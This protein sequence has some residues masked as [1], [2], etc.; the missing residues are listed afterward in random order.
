MQVAERG[1]AMTAKV[2]LC[3]NPNRSMAIDRVIVIA[4]SD[5]KQRVRV[6]NVDAL[7][8]NPKLMLPF[9]SGYA[10]AATFWTYAG[11][12]VVVAGVAL[13]FLWHWWAFMP[14]FLLA[15]L[16]LKTT[17]QNTAEVAQMLVQN[18][19]ARAHFAQLGLIWETSSKGIMPE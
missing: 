3:P 17:K 18:D 19:V 12:L 8:K 7:S 9:A 2:M 11:L 4:E 16:V 15:M 10:L 6:L 1:N 14:G 13:S 5:D